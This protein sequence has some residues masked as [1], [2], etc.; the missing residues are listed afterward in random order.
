MQLLGTGDQGVSRGYNN[1]S[2]SG[3]YALLMNDVAQ[4]GNEIDYHFSGMIAGQYDIYTYAVEPSGLT[5]DVQ[6]TVAAQTIPFSTSLG[7]CPGITA[8]S[9]ASPI[10]SII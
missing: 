4:I 9:W 1:S 3:D 6:V 2:N 5:V 8:L 7:R 10:P